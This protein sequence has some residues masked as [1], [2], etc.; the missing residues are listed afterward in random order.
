[1]KEYGCRVISTGN[2][3]DGLLKE[4]ER[5]FKELGGALMNNNHSAVISICADLIKT[6]NNILELE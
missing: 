2:L 4:Q 5:E 6:S 3:K 1:M